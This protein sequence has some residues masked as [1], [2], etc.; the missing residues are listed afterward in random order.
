M[1][2]SRWRCVTAPPWSRRLRLDR[3]GLYHGTDL[4]R[5]GCLREQSSGCQGGQVRDPSQVLMCVCV[6]SK[7]SSK[8]VSGTCGSS[9]A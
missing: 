6:Y 5:L 8:A 2:S 1:A 4:G 3:A 9:G 7:S